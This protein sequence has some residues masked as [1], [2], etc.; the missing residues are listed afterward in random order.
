[1]NLKAQGLAAVAASALLCMSAPAFGQTTVSVG[2]TG[3]YSTTWGNSGGD[4]GA[5]IYTGTVNGVT[6]ASGI[7]CDDFNDEI[8][9][10]ETWNAKAYQVSTLVSSGNINNTLFGNP[11]N[12]NN[13]GV[14]GYAEVATLVSMMFSGGTSYGGITGITQAE[15]SS[16]IWD[17]TTPG[18]ITGLDSIASALVTAVEKAFGGNV[19]AATTYLASLS[20]LWILTPTPLGPGEPQEMWTENLA[21]PEGG[22]ALMYLLLATLFCGWAFFLRN[23]ERAGV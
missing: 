17:I 23:R 1:M 21:V 6:S 5:G 10:G 12:P 9:S 14:T 18:G 13:I 2:Y 22:A 15:L 4:Y 20:D 11:S 8:A 3:G 7:I 19:S 16:A